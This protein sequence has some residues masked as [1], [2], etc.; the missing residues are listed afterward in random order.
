MRR[1]FGVGFLPPHMTRSAASTADG[2]AFR[3]AFGSKLNA[4]PNRQARLCFERAFPPP[5]QPIW[6]GAFQPR[7]NHKPEI[8]VKNP[9]LPGPWRFQSQPLEDKLPPVVRRDHQ[10]LAAH[11]DR[12]PSERKETQD[13][14]CSSTAYRSRAPADDSFSFGLWMPRD[15]LSGPRDVG[16]SATNV[17]S[18]GRHLVSVVAEINIL[19]RRS[20]RSLS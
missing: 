2:F 16:T 11:H 10:S 20:F 17:T 19:A 4:I 8:A 1:R 3:V 7:S 6:A 12:A 14:C 15:P 18:C 9:S 13:I 5:V